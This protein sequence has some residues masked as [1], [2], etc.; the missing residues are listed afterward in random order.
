MNVSLVIPLLNEAESLNELHDW[1]VSQMQ[2][3]AYTYELIFVDDGSTDESWQI[4]DSLSK[5]NTSVKAVRFKR[6]YGKSQA[7]NAGFKMANGKVVITMDADLQ[8]NP[9]EIPELVKMIES[10]NYDLVSGWKKKRY[11]SFFAKNLPSKL[12]NWAARKTSGIQLH[13]FN[14]GLKAYKNEVVKAIDV[15]GEMH[16]YIPVLAKNAGYEGITEKVVQHQARKYGYTKFGADRF[17][18]GFLDLITIWFVSKFAKRPMHFFGSLGS[19]VFLIGFLF[20]LYLGI[21]KLYINTKGRL[22]T[23]RPEFYIALVSMII[24]TQLFLAG[25]ISEMISRNKSNKKRYHIN[26]F[27]NLNP[28]DDIH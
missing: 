13:D 20:A 3:N 25:F 14:C 6:N 26:S 17:I 12:F 23:Q 21:D 22:I 24:G 2:A 5:S 9:E 10:E 7:L 15:Y 18:N 1:I 8:D 4:I 28:K 11:D 16:R 19:L 27:L